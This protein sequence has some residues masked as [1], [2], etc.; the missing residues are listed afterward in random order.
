MQ[1]KTLLK[2]SS[3]LFS[4]E[5][6]PP[7]TDEGL[8]A[9]LETVSSLKDLNPSYVSITYGAGGNTRAKTVELVAKIKRDIGLETAAHLTCV[10]HSQN[11]LKDNLTELQQKGIENIV[12]LRGD[13]PK[14][15]TRFTPAPN[16][17][18]YASELTA[19][20][21]K[22]FQFSIGVAGYP[23]KHIESPSL[24]SDIQHLKEKIEAGG[25]FVIT[26]LFFDNAH[27]YSYVKRLRALGVTVPVVAGIMPITD[28]EQ[29]KR[30]T[31][32]CGASIPAPLLAKLESAA[33]DKEKIAEIG[34]EHSVSQ[35][36]DLLENKVPGIHFYTLNKSRSTRE[37]LERLKKCGATR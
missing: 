25:D 4:F 31:T 20:I 22:N 29:T 2:N 11:E 23:E 15:E 18:R 32:M 5:F 9:L 34:V 24:E 17:F 10:G 21:R 8:S 3:P 7:K 19:F 6:F 26:Q 12:A 33:T 16:G 37:I 27:Y 30:F 28:V 35:C 36:Q 13:P 1:I 14:G